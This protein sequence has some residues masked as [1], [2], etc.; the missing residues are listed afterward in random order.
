MISAGNSAAR[1]AGSEFVDPFDPALKRWAI[2]ASSA[3]ADDGI[4]W[5]DFLDLAS[6]TAEQIT[7]SIK[8]HLVAL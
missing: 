8:I 3:I 5:T 2:F 1:F 6:R 7:G 4:R